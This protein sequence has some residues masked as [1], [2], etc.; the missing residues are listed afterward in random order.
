LKEKWPQALGN[1]LACA[2]STMPGTKV[3]ELELA[4]ANGG[5]PP[6]YAHGVRRSK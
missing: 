3:D 2:Y 6:R 4:A 5:T 1:P